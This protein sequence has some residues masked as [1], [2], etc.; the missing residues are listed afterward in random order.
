MLQKT[1]HQVVRAAW[2]DPTV[3]LPTSNTKGVSHINSW[4]EDKNLSVIIVEI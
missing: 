3:P 1:P 2:D 4:T